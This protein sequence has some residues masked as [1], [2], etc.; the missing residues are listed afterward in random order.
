[1]MPTQ[2]SIYRK[3]LFI[4]LPLALTIAAAGVLLHGRVVQ[5]ERPL[6]TNQ[7]ATEQDPAPPALNSTPNSKPKPL[8]PELVAL[9]RKLQSAPSLEQEQERSRAITAKADAMIEQTDA[10]I[11][12]VGHPAVT[13]IEPQTEQELHNRIRELRAKASTLQER[14]KSLDQ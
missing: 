2:N 6:S 10:M 8:P 7:P 5:P 1:M 3:G 12:R 11:A 14:T 4:A 13:T 9:K